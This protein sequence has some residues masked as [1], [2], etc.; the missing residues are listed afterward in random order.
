MVK[1]HDMGVAFIESSSH[2]V[3]YAISLLRAHRQAMAGTRHRPMIRR[4]RVV[5][6]ILGL[7]CWLH[8]AAAPPRER[9]S[10][11]GRQGEEKLVV[12]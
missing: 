12:C 4:R 3:H 11:L 6:L 9:F 8:A 5:L 10:I 1:R 7:L 2:D